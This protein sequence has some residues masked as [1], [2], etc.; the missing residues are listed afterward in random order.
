[1]IEQARGEFLAFEQRFL[2]AL[3]LG[4]LRQEPFVYFLQFPGSLP[5]HLLQGPVQRDELFLRLPKDVDGGRQTA[6]LLLRHA[7]E[8]PVLQD[9]RYLAEVDGEQ[10][11][12]DV[13]DVLFSVPQDSDEGSHGPPRRGE[14]VEKG[15]LTRGEPGG[16]GA[17][18]LDHPGE[19]SVVDEGGKFLLDL[20]FRLGGTGESELES[21]VLLPEEEECSAPE[22]DEFACALV[23]ESE[24]GLYRGFRGGVRL[25]VVDLSAMSR[26]LVTAMRSSSREMILF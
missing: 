25:D 21:C 20:L 19:G 12:A 23:A 24:D 2:L 1:M 6:V 18:R 7:E 11:I 22:T 5:D 14:C 15:V 10:G 3:P 13:E 9:S 26:A 16:N 17:L 4:D 8:F